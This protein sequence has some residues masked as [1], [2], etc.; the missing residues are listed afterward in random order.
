MF[1][2]EKSVEK[3]IYNSDYEYLDHIGSPISIFVK[4]HEFDEEGKETQSF[5]N[6]YKAIYDHRNQ[7]IQHLVYGEN[8]HHPFKITTYDGLNRISKIEIERSDG[9]GKI[10]FQYFNR[11]LYFPD[12]LKVFSSKMG[13][14]QR[15]IINH[16]N[17]NLVTRRDLIENDTL[18][19][20]TLFEY[21]SKNNLTK[22]LNINT[23][24]GFG[25]INKL[26]Y[27]A[28]KTLYPNDSTLYN[29]K[30]SGDTMIINRER[31]VGLVVTEKKYKK[32][33]FEINIEEQTA[34]ENGFTFQK[35]THFKWT[36]STKIEHRYYK[37]KGVLK[38]YYN[39]YMY[40]DKIISKWINPIMMDNGEP[41]RQELTKIE[42]TYDKKGN[43]IKKVF[44]SSEFKKK[45]IKRTIE[46]F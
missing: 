17:D 43:W 13:A 42:T 44:I 10:V 9:H 27:S 22:E 19:Y 33:N 37:D 31:F 7:M 20:Y 40:P 21:D 15:K 34:R 45:E 5:S 39:T 3:F 38:S 26:G 6:N 46:Y 25:V 2:Q 16:F 32:D 41:E 28:T 11:N 14:L 8:S 4:K 23:N 1:S 24:N 36:D 29:H 30:T 35:S 18:R 12:S